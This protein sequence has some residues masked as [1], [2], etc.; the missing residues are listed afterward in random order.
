MREEI[1]LIIT[2]EAGQGLQTIGNALGKLFQRTGYHLF[3]DQDYMSRVR[4]GNNFYRLRVASRPVYAPRERADLVVCLDR[5]SVERQAGKAAG[6]GL[7][8]LDQKTF[9]LEARGPEYFDVPLHD[10]AER[11]GGSA[12][13][14][15]SVAS[16]LVAGLLR[17]D[18][19]PVERIIRA[20]FAGKPDEVVDKNVNSA[21]AGYDHGRG[22][23][24]DDRFALPPGKP[25]ETLLFNGSEAIGLGAIAAGCKFYS[26]YP[27]TPSTGVLNFL[28]HNMQAY[29]ILVE[30]AEDELAAVN[31]ALGASFAG[32][33]A[34]TGTSGGGFA[35]MTEG[36]SLA[37]MTE[38][39]IVIMDSQRPAPATGFP[40][41]TEQADLDLVL[42]AG[43]GEFARAIFAPGTPEEAFHLTRR[44]FNLAEKY[45]VPVI[46]LNDQ[47]LADCTRD[48]P[49][50]DLEREPVERHLLPRGAKAGGYQRYALTPDGVSPRAVPSWLETPIW[51]DS[52]EHTEEGHIT[53]D[54]ALRVRMVE[55]RLNLKMAGLAREVVPPTVSNADGADLVLVGF[56]SNYGVLRETAEASPGGKKVGFVHL[57]QVWP[58]PAAEVIAALQNARKFLVVE[59]NATGQL[60]RL[61]QRETGLS[62]NGRILQYDGRPFTLEGLA[63]KI[64]SELA[65]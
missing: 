47:H 56:G 11:H 8:V 46:I 2:G 3:T 62:P 17:M 10:L 38:T 50:L 4:G 33:R 23:F 14:M 39:P 32:A 31:M 29:G 22:H 43:H 57:S 30:Q 61:L 65:S 49:G 52:D 34:M 9:Q 51:A 35:L 1:N 28:A 12:L 40:T 16:G 25:R 60:A 21:R 19:D 13:Y 48:L 6:G 55:K 58:F 37:A 59:N 27:M 53:E 42:H 54:G 7:V 26:A 5:E 36:L 45:Q 41:R 24:R 64:E 20:S 63:R 18:F 15:N 44:A